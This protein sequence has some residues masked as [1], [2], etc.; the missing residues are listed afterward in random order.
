MCRYDYLI[1]DIGSTYTKQRLFKDC[2]LMATV[3]SPTTVEN[4]YKGIKAGQDIIKE[5]LKESRIEAKHV[6]A[7][8]SAAGGLRMVAMGYMTRVTAK[9]AKEVAMNSG[10]KILEIVSNENLPEYRI[11]ILKEINPDII[12]LAGGTDFGDES[13]IIENASL[14]VESG[15]K[16]VVVIAGNINA[17][18]EV[19]KILKAGN[20]AHLRV[21]NIMPT[22]HKLRVKE[23]RE[24]IHR[25]FI[26]QITKAQGL[27]I[28]Q[29]EITNDK[30]IPTPGAVLMASELLA[31][32]TY[33]EKGIGEIIVVDLGGAT[34]D[35]HSV[36][37]GYAN[38]EDEEIGLIVSNEKQMS[39]RTVEGNLGM[40]IS[41]MGVLDTVSPRAI[42]HKRGIKDEELLEEFTQYCMEIE[43]TPRRIAENE[44]EYM[45][46]TFIAETAVEVA[47]KRHAGFISTV[48]D[49]ITGIM[50]G[51]PIGRDLRNVNTIIGVGGIFSHRDPSEGKEI[52]K[53]ALKD[54]GISLLPNEPKIIID[55][56][57]I[58]YTGGL[59]SQVD[60]DYAFQVLK[61][62][63]NLK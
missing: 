36:I 7:S 46:D 55:E 33:L 6:L 31:K 19:A 34:T 39:Y 16:G 57:Y 41:A 51:M 63:F 13:S 17:Q 38:L 27:S 53:N 8:S 61:N 48:A 28:L 21:P 35:I 10:S 26:K 29:E 45:F 59:I 3:Q 30:I 14:I 9:A 22:I 1:I 43:K 24:A 12:L 5:T 44:K 52:I 18:A 62:S 15:V 25:E 40:R 2:E 49:P 56:N 37:P 54:K 32:G 42:F 47:L 58:L 60:E 4:V 20:V 23:A 50:P 11:Q